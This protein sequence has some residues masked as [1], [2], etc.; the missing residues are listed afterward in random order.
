MDLEA[1]EPFGGEVLLVVVHVVDAEFAIEPGL[2][3]MAVALDGDLIPVGHLSGA[4]TLFGEG[5]HM[6]FVAFAGEEPAAA[7]FVIEAG[8]P[9]ARCVVAFAL[10]AVDAAL[11]IH[12]AT[13]HAAGIACEVIELK[14]ESVNEVAVGFVR[15]EE[16]IA[17]QVV[18]FAHDHAFFHGVVG[19]GTFDGPAVESVTLDQRSEAVFCES[20]RREIADGIWDGLK[21]GSLSEEGKSE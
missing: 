13:E 1:E 9:G 16:G 19:L 12:E 6:F 7:G 14:L 2:E 11:F 15:A 17:P 18:P 5:S 20:F 21:L 4:L 3:V 8:G 10:V